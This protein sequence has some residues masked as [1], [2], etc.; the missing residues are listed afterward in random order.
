MVFGEYNLCRFF[1]TRIV[2]VVEEHIEFEDFAGW[3]WTEE[4]E[5]PDKMDSKKMEKEFLN[6]EGN[7]INGLCVPKLSH[8]LFLEKEDSWAT[9]IQGENSKPVS[10]L[11]FELSALRNDP[12]YIRYEYWLL[13]I[14]HLQQKVS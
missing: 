9:E 6:P 7:L 5:R 3:N 4:E 1:E 14:S 12:D 11:S 10:R 2:T 8:I 13:V